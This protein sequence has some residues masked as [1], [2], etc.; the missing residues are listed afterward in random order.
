M[1]YFTAACTTGMG[2]A[3]KAGIAAEVLANSG[4]SIGGRIY[5]SKIYIETADLFAWTAMVIVMSVLLERLMVA[6]MN[7]VG[8]KYKVIR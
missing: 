4:L 3:W 6:L 2:L 1:P 7:K 5:Q 8:K